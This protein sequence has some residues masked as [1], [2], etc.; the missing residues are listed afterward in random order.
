MLPFLLLTVFMLWRLGHRIGGGSMG[1]WLLAICLLDPVLLGQSVLVSPDIV[2]VASFLCAMAGIV[3][4]RRYWVFW[5]V[6]GLCAISMRGMMT[7]G[8]LL[9]WGAVLPLSKGFSARK[10]WGNALPFL[11]GFAFAAWFLS[12]HWMAT[13]WLGYHP[14]S[15][16]ASAFKLVGPQEFL[17]NIAVLGWRWLDFGRVGELLLFLGLAI[18]ALRYDQSKNERWA[19]AR[20]TFATLLLCLF[21]F[22]LPSALLYQNLSAHRYLLPAFLA[23]HLFV[24]QMVANISAERKW[25]LKPMLLFVLVLSLASGNLWSYPRGI[26]MGWDS[27][28]AHWPY[29]S[30]RA[31]AVQYL[32]SKNIDF[33]QV[34]TAFPNVNTGEDLML[35][36]DMR[37]FSEKDF[38][39]NQFVMASNVFN[40]FSEADFE[41]LSR[42]WRLV[43]RKK[44]GVVWVEVYARR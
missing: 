20:H 28:L 40:D 19:W 26:S 1:A 31:E 36:G 7:A 5:G 8:A 38:S 35:N 4:Q 21:T 14:G 23:M 27:T 34:G 42:D 33:A 10:F 32:E 16:W 37:R 12:W 2:L 41:A 17:K 3:E 13:G 11:P 30:L 6:L 9:L 29:Q 44:K 43:W 22:S 24:F 25:R 18:R 15:P 39:K